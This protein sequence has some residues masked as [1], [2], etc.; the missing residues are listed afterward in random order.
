MNGLR[1]DLVH[2]DIFA[3]RDNLD[4]RPSTPLTN[5]LVNDFW[6]K[7][8]SNPISHKSYRPLT[9]L[10]FRLNY[11]L[12][13][14]DT[15]GYHAVNIGLHV[16]VTCLFGCLCRRVVF[17]GWRNDV[18]FIAMCLFATHPVHTEAVSVCGCVF[19]GGGRGGGSYKC[20]Y[21]LIYVVMNLQFSF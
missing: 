17:R 13:G 14:L 18:G 9:V 8:M 12:H 21:V 4:L 6:G 20:M 2:D 3:I 16:L 7:S 15:W 10:S 5:L 19:G 11:H 1:G